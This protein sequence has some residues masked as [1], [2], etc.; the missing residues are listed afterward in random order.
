MAVH[1]DVKASTDAEQQL[2]MRVAV[3]TVFAAARAHFAGG[4]KEG[5]SWRRPPPLTT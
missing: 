2:K 3:R 1:L 4:Y 5:T